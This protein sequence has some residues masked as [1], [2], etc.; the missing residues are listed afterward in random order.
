MNDTGMMK[1]KWSFVLVH[2]RERIFK[3]L[4]TPTSLKVCALQLFYLSGALPEFLFVVFC[5]S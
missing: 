2:V 5:A 1:S 4:V 3:K